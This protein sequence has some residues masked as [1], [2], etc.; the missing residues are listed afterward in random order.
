MERYKILVEFDR[1]TKHLRVTGGKAPAW[2]IRCVG[3]AVE[4]ML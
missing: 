2:L 1:E 4:K 3:E